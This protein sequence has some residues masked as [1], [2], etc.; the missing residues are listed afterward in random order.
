MKNF[1][2]ETLKKIKDVGYELKDVIFIGSD[3]GKYRMS[4]EKFLE[5]SDFEY[6]NDFGAT[7]IATDL[8]VYF[9][10]NSYMI[11]E[12][13]D[14]FEW[15]EYVKLIKY[16]AEDNFENFNILGGK[17]HYWE[18]VEEMNNKVEE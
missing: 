10:D 4:V 11:R 9:N 8:I 13:N 3:D 5:F 7:N 12:T 1:K 2:E 15:W 17:G 18:T 14:N 16:T 6:N